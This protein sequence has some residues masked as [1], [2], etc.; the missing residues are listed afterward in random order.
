MEK[1]LSLGAFEE[2]SENAM[3]ET[4]GGSIQGFFNWIC[5]ATAA[6]QAAK[7]QY[8]DCRGRIITQIKNNPEI[9]TSVPQASIE[10]FNIHGTNGGYKGV[11]G[12][13]H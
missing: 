10:Y 3:M 8:N 6:E 5:G 4:E 7:E 12:G 13:I 2:L 1:T 9:I 11:Q